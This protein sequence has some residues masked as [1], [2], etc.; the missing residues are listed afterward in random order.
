MMDDSG[1][2]Q[3]QSKGH[4]L[5]KWSRMLT[6]IV[7]TGWLPI[8][9]GELY[10]TEGPQFTQEPSRS[11][12]FTNVQGLVLHCDVK[13]SPQPQVQWSQKDGQPLLSYS[14]IREIF[15]NGTIH[16]P[17]FPVS[18]YRPDVHDQI[19]VCVASN[20]NGKIRSLDIYVRAVINQRY[21][22][23]AEDA[24]GLEG[25]D[26]LFNCVIPDSV[27]D[28]VSV[29]SWIKDG[30]LNIFPHSGAGGRYFTTPSGQLLIEDVTRNDSFATFR[31]RTVNKL[32]GETT[33]SE[34]SA[35]LQLPGGSKSK[36]DSPPSITS[37]ISKLRLREGD[38]GVLLCLSDGSPSPSHW[39]MR[40]NGVHGGLESLRQT[41]RIRIRKSA[42]IIEN[43][44]L[45][46]A[47]IYVCWRNNTSGSDSFQIRLVVTSPLTVQVIPPVLTMDIGKSAEF[48]CWTN[49]PEETDQSTER[50][51]SW[52]KDGIELKVIEI[53]SSPRLSITE[54]GEKLRIANVQREDKGIYQ[55]FVKFDSDMAQAAAELRLGDAAPQLVYRFIEQTLSPKHGVSL[56]CSAS[57]GPTPHIS[58]TLDSFPVPQSERLLIGQYVTLHGDVVS[59]VNI[60]STRVEDGGE[61][62]CTASNRLG[63]NF[64]SARLNI[65][66]PPIVRNM[67]ASMTAVAGKD[68]RIKCPVAGFPIS[69]IT[70]EK[71][72]Q[73][74]PLTRRQLVSP[75]GTL[76]VKDVDRSSDAGFYVCSATNNKGNSDRKGFQL[77]VVVPPTVVPFSFPREV[78]EGEKIFVT[79]VVSQGDAPMRLQ[80][81]KNAQVVGD[82]TASPRKENKSGVKHPSDLRSDLSI[83]RI[84]DSDAL[85]LQITHVKFEHGSNWTCK[86]KNPFGTQEYTQQLV[87]HVPPKWT[88]EPKDAEFTSNSQIVLD[89]NSEG[90]PAPVMS[91]K[92]AVGNRPENYRDIP[93]QSTSPTSSSLGSITLQ[94]QPG[95][96]V[97]SSSSE[98]VFSLTNGSLI[99]KSA[100]KSHQGFYLCEA[101]NGIGS[102]L[103]KVIRLAIN[104][105]VHV[106]ELQRNVS[107][108]VGGRAMLRCEITGDGPIEV[109]W[110]KGLVELKP[111]TDPRYQVRT[112]NSSQGTFTSELTINN[113]GREDG[114]ERYLCYSTNHHGRSQGNVW[115]YVQEPPPSV[116]NL[117]VISKG[118]RFVRVGWQLTQD[119]NSPIIQFIIKY[120]LQSGKSF[121]L[122][123]SKC[124]IHHV[125]FALIIVTFSLN[126]SAISNDFHELTVPGQVFAETV[127][128]LKPARKYSLLI[129]AENQVGQSEHSA[130]LE[131]KT[132]GEPP[133]GA[134]KNVR[135]SAVSVSDIQV[136]WSH[137]D[138]E[139]WHSEL[140]LGYYV[141]YKRFR[142]GDQYQF[143]TVE[144]QDGLQEYQIVLKELFAFSSYEIVVQAFNANGAGPNSDSIVATTLEDVPI[145]APDGLHCTS[146]TS[147]SLQLGWSPLSQEQAR[148]VI[149]GYK[150]LLEK[151]DFDL[152]ES[153]EPLV[154]TTPSTNII[155]GGLAKYKNYSVQVQ[156]FTGAGPGPLSQ[157][158]TFCHTEEDLPGN[159]ASVKI[160]INPSSPTITVTWLPP[161]EPNGILTKYTVYISTPEVGKGKDAI[162]RK[163][164]VPPDVTKFQFDGLRMDEKYELRITAS[165]KIGEGNPAISHKLLIKTVQSAIISFGMEFR[166][167]WKTDLRLPCETV[168]PQPIQWTRLIE[169]RES[170][171]LSGTQEGSLMIRNARD[172]DSGNYSCSINDNKGHIIDSI[173]HQVIVQVPP[174]GPLL[175]VAVNSHSSLNLQW[176]VSDTGGAPIRGYI[177]HL[178]ASGEWLERSISRHLT[179]YEL[180][181]LE[182][183]TEY[184]MYLVA[185]NRA[186][187]GRASELLN[188]STLGDPPSLS[189]VAPQFMVETNQT[190]ARVLLRDVWSGN[191]CPL[192]KFQVLFKESGAS[193]WQAVS[194]ELTGE[195]H[196]AE[197]LGLRGGTTYQVKVVATNTAGKSQAEVTI[198]TPDAHD[199]GAE[200]SNKIMNYSETTPFYS[201]I[202]LM[203]PIVLSS[204]TLLIAVSG[205]CLCFHRKAPV[206]YRSTDQL[207]MGTSSSSTYFK[208]NHRNSQQQVYMTVKKSTPMKGVDVTDLEPIPQYADDIHPYATFELNENSRDSKGCIL[209][210][211]LERRRSSNQGQWN[212]NAMYQDKNRSSVKPRS[213]PRSSMKQEESEEYD[214]GSG[215]DTERVDPYQGF[216]KSHTAMPSRLNSKFQDCDSHAHGNRYEF[217]PPTGANKIRTRQ[218]QSEIQGMVIADPY[219]FNDAF[220][221]DER[222]SRKPNKRRSQGHSQTT[223]MNQEATEYPGLDL[224]LDPPYGFKDQHETTNHNKKINRKSNSST[225]YAIAV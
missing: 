139:T 107:S 14:G 17:P 50:Q 147:H 110:R 42:V 123:H 108:R 81:L 216:N 20:S 83:H 70:F 207:S 182:C 31:C 201:D 91:W 174:L 196:S 109:G 160:S 186:G 213:N 85:V 129:I 112:L 121:R 111:E 98:D 57:A 197:L 173:M 119:G 80:W 53:R 143:K 212:Q 214:S 168:G 153:S 23:R 155:I 203:I 165:T 195:S 149:K 66:G 159:P 72:G 61:W 19:I 224:S 88:L 189:L 204:F 105:P 221:T 199:L 100:R 48:T 90:Y 122:P 5:R 145:T 171:R 138:R 170:E 65:Y 185:F 1:F 132:D 35:R 158:L 180:R 118:S 24:F 127:A 146:L 40:S 161:A 44:G 175:N 64:H 200:T 41:E 4:Q 190:W 89:C 166:V 56:K 151:T 13:G 86:A 164:Q 142:E 32:T 55:C 202:R 47:G 133:E 162:K 102:G 28:F 117:H 49:S 54:S 68:F 106:K 30:L 51:I 167:V 176:K 144:R 169:N 209:I 16:F 126:I 177:L 97:I 52:R 152:L 84:G 69:S 18:F 191:G 104:V 130:L 58:W 76:I 154:R 15:S 115:L 148:G 113:V 120:R 116:R 82:T 198:N 163:R 220:P 128:N 92:R 2:F 39:W 29:T 96:G 74:L 114:E 60:T 75:D 211:T 156:S 150:V 94:H 6:L 183:G 206:E 192:N 8:I 46:D 45:Q 223:Q 95:G 141:G 3:S 181:D 21:E 215:T 26:I 87:V 103:S 194:A 187:M 219:S 73:T 140:L 172:S 79:C 217:A 38:V 10:D 25:S 12:Y 78:K 34:N 93:V 135:V 136:T 184:Q 62:T 188:V 131:I 67:P 157:P 208:Q 27:K 99:I 77:N 36:P 205:I 37:R 178:K 125:H 7:L 210:P 22:V 63:S 218:I 222:R 59:H 9:L 71:D 33:L 124:Y 193:H 11:N 101:S 179:F 137:P 134:P 43:V 225:E